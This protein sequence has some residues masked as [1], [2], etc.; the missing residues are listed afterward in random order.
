MVSAAVND[1]PHYYN[2]N[3]LNQ[4]NYEDDYSIEKN[5]YKKS[6]FAEIERFDDKL[7]VCDNGIVVDDRT[8]CPLKCPFGTTLDGVYVMDLDICKIETETMAQKCGPDTDMPGVLAM[9]QEQ[10]NIF[11]QCDA[12]SPL[13][14]A[15]GGLEPIKVADIQLCQLNVPGMTV[16]GPPSFFAGFVVEDEATCNTVLDEVSVCGPT[17]DLAGMLTVNT[18]SSCNLFETCAANSPLGTALGNTPVDVIDSELCNLVIPPETEVFT[19]PLDTPMAGAVVTDLLLCQAPNDAN[20]CPAE[21]DLQGVY[22]MDTAS[23][24]NIFATCEAGTPLGM[25]LGDQPVKVADPVLC[26]LNVPPEIELFQCDLSTQMEGAI[27]TDEL[28]CQAPN[29]NN[30][31]PNNSDLPGVYVMNP[32]TQCKIVYESCDE[33]TPLGMALGLSPG[34]TVQVV[35]DALCALSVPEAVQ[36][37]DCPAGSTLGEGALVTNSQLC[38]ALVED[39]VQCDVGSVLEGVI[40]A[41]EDAATCDLQVPPVVMCPID[42]NNP[43]SGAIV[44]D[45][46]LCDAPTDAIKCPALNPDN[47]PTDLPGVY[48][49]NSPQQCNIVYPTCDNTTPV[50]VALGLGVTEEVEV[51]DSAICQLPFAECEAGTVLGEG[52][53]VTDESLCNVPTDTVKCED[54]T[55][56]DG[57]YVMEGMEQQLCNLDVVTPF[58]TTCV[59]D[60][61]LSISLG[62]AGSDIT[63]LDTNICQTSAVVE[64]SEDSPLAVS[65]NWNTN[66]DGP[67]FVTNPTLC[68]TSGVVVCGQETVNAGALVTDERLCGTITQTQTITVNK[69]TDC[70]ADRVGQQVCDNIPDAKIMALGNNTNPNF[71]L[72]SQ[73]PVNVTLQDGQYSIMEKDFVTGFERC[74]DITLQFEAGRNLP[75]FGSDDL[76]ICSELSEE[77]MG[78]A[79]GDGDPLSC[80][81]NNVVFPRVQDIVTANF[82]SNEI[83]VFLGNGDGTFGTSTQFTI[84]GSSPDPASV[85]VGFFNEDTNLDIVTANFFSNE[86]SVFLGN[87]DGTFGTSTQFTVGGSNPSPESVAVGF[88]NADTNL[89]IVTA[90]FNT[91][92]ISV[93]LGNGDGTFGTSTQFTIGGT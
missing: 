23:D 86:I 80:N 52:A 69:T 92:E 50:G 17:T 4:Y 8:Q 12:D 82:F 21:T 19:C 60:D 40:V 16:C 90:N 78:T 59:D 36:L 24:C 22:V 67:L 2:D 27:V 85:A 58:T 41:S 31:C 61:P 88:F 91:D 71:F 44:T 9:N 14:L 30:K 32:E 64:C 51:V 77:C 68:N 43:M 87:G 33:F 38:N 73:T 6:S 89:D 7:F 25:A 62:I 83:S 74:T 81:M 37:F 46:R 75:E 65:N 34:Q 45:V 57:F 70:D 48:V 15:L 72:E 76:F 13:G 66:T 11:A 54:G 28:L 56:F 10:C 18:E 39:V 49:M 29:N 79:I 3:L 47:T 26:T 5:K 53:I 63:V 1:S 20:K 84:G 55:I 42:N 35:D 93:F